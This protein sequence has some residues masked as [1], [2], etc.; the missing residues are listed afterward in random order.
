LEVDKDDEEEEDDVS[1]TQEVPAE[2]E[3]EEGEIFPS[4]LVRCNAV[5]L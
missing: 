2:S 4:P 1:P 5:A 3:N